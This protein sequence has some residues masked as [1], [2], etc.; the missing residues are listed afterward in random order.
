LAACRV[1]IADFNVPKATNNDLILWL[2]AQNFGLESTIL[3]LVSSSLHR[4]RNVDCLK[5]IPVTDNVD[6]S[7]NGRRKHCNA[8]YADITPYLSTAHILSIISVAFP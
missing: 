1:A 5:D 2:P 4:T 8:L 6:Q 7:R 3:E